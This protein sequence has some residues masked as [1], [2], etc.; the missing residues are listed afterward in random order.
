MLIFIMKIIICIYPTA[1]NKGALNIACIDMWKKFKQVI[2]IHVVSIY[3]PG[4]Y[5]VSAILQ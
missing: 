3:D 2:V 4:E 5:I 1:I